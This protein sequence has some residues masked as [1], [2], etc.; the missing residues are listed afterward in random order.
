MPVVLVRNYDD[1]HDGDEKRQPSIF[2]LELVGIIIIYCSKRKLGVIVVV[3][4]NLERVC[5][6]LCRF[7][8]VHVQG[9]W[10]VR[11]IREKKR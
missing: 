9:A 3:V 4:Q 10:L 11:Y 7:I 2:C 8:I 1:H 5:S 6:S